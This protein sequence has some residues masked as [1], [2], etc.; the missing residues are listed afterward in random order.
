MTFYEGINSE[1]G[2]V[3]RMIW[4]VGRVTAYDWPDYMQ[5]TKLGKL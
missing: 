3:L 1:H 4:L 2:L 5:G